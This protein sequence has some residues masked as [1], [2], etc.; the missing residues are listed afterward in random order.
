MATRS[1]TGHGS[2]TRA[3]AGDSRRRAGAV[4]TPIIHSSTFS[5]DSLESM[6]VERDRGAAGAFYQRLGHPTLRACE[7][8]LAGLEGTEEALLFPSGMSAITGVLLANL[9]AK[10]H[11]VAEAFAGDGA[12]VKDE[13]AALVKQDGQRRPQENEAEQAFVHPGRR[14]DHDFAPAANA[15]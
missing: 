12:G 3:V 8:R 11:V 14:V 13:T 15:E 7:E 5:F 2:N 6:L 4:S 10:D 1:R 9:H